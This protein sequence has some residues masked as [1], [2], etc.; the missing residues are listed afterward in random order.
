MRRAERV[1]LIAVL[2]AGFLAPP[3]RQ[4]SAAVTILVP[5]GSVWKYRD[6]GTNQGTAWRAAGFADGS[7]ASGAAQLG[8]GDGDEAT[9]V[10]FGPNASAKYVTTYFRRAFTVANPSVFAA[11]NLRLLRDD[12]A[13][14]YLNGAEVFRSNMP[15]GTIG[16]TT[17]ASSALGA[18]A[19]STFVTASVPASSLVAGTNVLAVEVHQ[20]NGTSSDLSFDLELSGST[21]A[22]VTRGP[23]LQT[24]TP[25]SAIVRWRTDVATGSRVR[26]G[27]A[28]E[29]LTGIADGAS[30]VTEHTVTVTGLS[31]DTLYYYSVGTS[32]ETLAGGDATF[33]FR[34]H[35]LVG[36]SVP[37]RVWVLGDSGTANASAQAVR[38]AYASFTGTR[39][40]DVWLMLGDNAYETGTD[41]EYQA[42]VFNMY[43]TFLKQAFLWPTLGNHDTA[44]SSNPPAS[45]PYYQIFNLP[46]NGASGG[47]PSGTE[48]YYSFDRGNIHFVC[49]DSMTSSRSSTGPM[50]TWLA[51]DLAATTQDWLIAYWHHPPYSK[52]SHN[53]DTETQLVEMR[54]NILPILED[55]GVDLV[56]TGHSHSYERSFLLDGHYGTSG[57]LTQS[58]IKD[59]G[60][61]RPSATGAYSKPT[62]G[63]EGHEGAVYAVA[64]SSGKI[65]GGTLNHP[66]MFISLNQLGSMVLD[67]DGNRLDAVFLRE[68][69]VVT[70]SFTIVKGTAPP[71]TATP[72]RTA[73]PVAATATPTRTPTPVP[74]TATATRTPTP[75]PPT[76]TPTRTPTPVPPTATATRTPTP[77]PP[78]ATPTRTPTPVPPTA[79]STPVPPTATATRTPTPVPPT[80]TSTSTPVPPTATATP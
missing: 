5:T 4:A 43:P 80:A 47:T 2:A 12:G 62:E 44:G 25:T 66:A 72:T 78:T 40:T 79:T 54:A 71:P 36:T 24:G 77:V 26:Y 65:S 6:N 59:G 22:S 58:M 32:T 42:A 1:F 67:V 73:T 21:G 23:Y 70:D 30:G 34:T 31:P 16:Y 51:N 18:P 69:G 17:P 27:T 20:A 45:L 9:V 60:S 28:P 35:P 61:G 76:A 74:P 13:V 55:Y 33:F 11:F 53:S 48:D 46:A 41:A 38:N 14:V 68:T 49:L 64:G 63:L 37:T 57:T 7:W 3:A 39:E 29:S 50:A 19:E 56:L 10:S 52:G 8:Y 15:A 75:V